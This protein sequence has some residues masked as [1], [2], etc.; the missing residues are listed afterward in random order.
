MRSMWKK[1]IH[2]LFLMVFLVMVLGV[3][4]M[5]SGRVSLRENVEN[6][7]PNVPM[8]AEMQALIAQNSQTI[9]W[10]EN[11][12]AIDGKAYEYEEEIINLL[13]L[14]ID[15]EGDIEEETE[16]KTWGVGQADAIFLLSINPKTQKVNIIG[17]PRNAMVDL[18]V[19][20]GEGQVREVIYNQICLQYP[21]ACGGENG[22]KETKKDVS[23]ILYDLP[24]HGVFAISEDAITVVNDMVGGVEL[25]VL[26][27]LTKWDKTLEKGKR[28]TLMGRSAYLYVQKRDITIT[29]TTKTRFERQKQYL[30]EM[31]KKA[32]G[33]VAEDPLLVSTLY[34]ACEPYMSTDISLN[35]A[36]YLAEQVLSYDFDMEKGIYL[37]EGEDA[38]NEG[39]TIEGNKNVYHDL[40]LDE[41][42]INQVMKQVFCQEVNLQ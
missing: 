27:D 4:Y 36:I 8:T 3:A 2:A 6:T 28:V 19:F 12:I 22:M 40:Y 7:V 25:E 5:E 24:V 39:I 35:E 37:L 13:F 32:K 20:N 41:K 9:S 23:H 42:S 33:L 15:R 10:Q 38:Y 21:Y 30:K 31:M 16:Y 29:G 11:W 18:E 1:I 14:G 17:I 26:E 34:Q